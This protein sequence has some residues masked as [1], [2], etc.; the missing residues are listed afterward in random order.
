MFSQW[1][2][3]R[4]DGIETA[5]ARCFAKLVYR[6]SPFR[7]EIIVLRERIC[8]ENCLTLSD[9]DL[10]LYTWRHWNARASQ[11]TQVD[12]V[13]KGRSFHLSFDQLDLFFRKSVFFRCSFNKIYVQRDDDSMYTVVYYG[14]VMRVHA[15]M[16]RRSCESITRVIRHFGMAISIMYT[17]YAGRRCPKTMTTWMRRRLLM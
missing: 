13:K 16:Q 11:K 1:K 10:V 8:R 14:C 15:G 5:C 4:N 9:R 3:L 6:T 7:S 2:G 17:G 12:H